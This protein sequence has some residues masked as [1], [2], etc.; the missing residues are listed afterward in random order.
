MKAK[1]PSIQKRIFRSFA[2]FAILVAL[3]NK[4][5]TGYG[6]N[7]YFLEKVGDIASPSTVYSNLSAL[8]RRGLI[9]CITDRSGR[10]YA[11]TKEGEKIAEAMPNT[12]EEIKQFLDRLLIP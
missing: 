8:E 5:M 9:E 10:L 6:I 1:T 11:L 7:Y 4:P 2:D 12:S 3:K